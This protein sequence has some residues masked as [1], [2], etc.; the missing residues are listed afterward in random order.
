MASQLSVHRLLS[1]EVRCTDDDDKK[2]WIKIS[3]VIR[4]GCVRCYGDRP[5]P[6][7][8]AS[9]I[10]LFTERLSIVAY[11]PLCMFSLSRDTVI[12]FHIY[13]CRHN[14]LRHERLHMSGMLHQHIYLPVYKC[15]YPKIIHLLVS[16]LHIVCT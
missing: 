11:V 4:P 2:T 8:A 10:S 16:V 6:A 5:L 13:Y 1:T 12:R 15:I 7:A 14:P 9:D 3:C